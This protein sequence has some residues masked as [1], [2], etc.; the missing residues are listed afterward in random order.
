MNPILL[1]FLENPM[2]G[3]GDIELD[4]VD[5]GGCPVHHGCRFEPGDAHREWRQQRV[6][7]LLSQTLEGWNL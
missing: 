3:C 5:C 6:Y 7:E 2:Q 1:Y 4:V